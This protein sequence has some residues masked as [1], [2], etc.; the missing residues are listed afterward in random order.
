MSESG[1]ACPNV[2]NRPLFFVFFAVLVR[3]FP[4]FAETRSLD[5][6]FPKL[7]DGTRSAAFSSTGY[8]KSSERDSGFSRLDSSGLDP[9]ISGAVLDKNPLFLVESL[10][11]IP[12]KNRKSSLLDVYNALGNIRGLKGRL[13]H[14]HTRDRD[15]PLFEDATRVKSAG[16]TSSVPD[17]GPASS[18]PDSET[19]YIRLKDVNF[20]NSY[21]RGDMVLDGLGL[22]YRLSNNR[23]LTYLFIPVIKEEKFIAQ[24]YFEIIEEGVLVYS[25]AGADVSSFVSSKIDMP[26]AI[27]K[28]VAVIVSWAADGIN[29]TGAR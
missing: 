25:I 12:P 20:G 8:I 21:Y 3:C 26:S 19:V 17:P 27:S 16:R 28:R 13:Y 5:E 9:G 18:I 10:L 4:V 24:L 2:L 11:V 6:I 23:N 14:S 29:N 7:P 1:P 22:R 15:V